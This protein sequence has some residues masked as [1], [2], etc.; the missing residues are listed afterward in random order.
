MCTL[1]R[2]KRDLLMEPASL[3]MPLL[4]FVSFTRSLPACVQHAS[5]FI[6]WIFST[7]GRFKGVDIAYSSWKPVPSCPD[8]QAVS[9]VKSHIHVFHHYSPYRTPPHPT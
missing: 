4:V 7:S 2:V 3:S 9:E 1:P 5:L 6:L 8:G